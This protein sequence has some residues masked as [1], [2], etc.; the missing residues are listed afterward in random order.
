MRRKRAE[1]CRAKRYYDRVD[2]VNFK[3]PEQEWSKSAY[4]CLRARLAPV[5]RLDFQAFHLIHNILLSSHVSLPNVS[6]T[7]RAVALIAKSTKQAT[8][9]AVEYFVC[10]YAFSAF[11]DDKRTQTIANHDLVREPRK[12]ERTEISL[13]ENHPTV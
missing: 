2:G 8:R 12:F 1:N 3:E 10:I 5:H 6:L 7:T 11:N 4:T 13:L 9:S